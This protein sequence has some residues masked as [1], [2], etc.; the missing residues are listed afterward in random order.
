MEAHK[1]IFIKE[2]IGR[3]D[4]I[5][6]I[7]VYQRNYSWEAIHTMHLLND[8]ETI[9]ESGATKRHF[10]GSIVVLLEEAMAFSVQ[11]YTLIDGQQRITTFMLLL[12]AISEFYPELRDRI[13]GE[14]LHNKYGKNSEEQMKLHLLNEDAEQFNNLL[15]N[16]KDSVRKDC[17]MM[18]SYLTC[19][20]CVERWYRRF[21]SET[22]LK[23][24][25]MLEVVSI[26]LKMGEDDPQEIFESINSTG[27]PLS[28]ADL[29]RNFLLMGEREQKRLYDDYWI[30]LERL[31]KSIND[32]NSLDQFFFVFLQ[33]QSVEVI[34]KER[35]YQHFIAY[36]KRSNH[37]SKADFMCTLNHAAE[38]YASFFAA[39]PGYSP[40]IQ[41]L[42]RGLRELDQTTIYPF[43]YLIFNDY[44][45][46]IITEQVLE[47]TLQL[48]LT[49]LVRRIV[50]GVPSN[51]LKSLFCGLY[52][53]VFRVEANKKR[54]C[55]AI[56]KFLFTLSSRDKFPSEEDFLSQLEKV[57]LYS[58]LRLCRLILI[59]LENG[60]SKEHVRMDNMTIEH[61]MPQKLNAEWV[62][63]SPEEHNTYL[64]TLGNLTLTAMNAELSNNSF[65]K[66]KGIFRESKARLLNRDVI[67]KQTWNIID[68]QQRAQ[69]LARLVSKRFPAHAVNDPTIEFETAG[70]LT[71]ETPEL[72][73]GSKILSYIYRGEEHTC[74]NYYTL[75][76]ELILILDRERP[77]MLHEMVRRSRDKSSKGFKVN[78]EYGA[79]NMRRSIA[80][81][82]N[83]CVDIHGSSAT[84]LRKIR[85]LFA[86]YG[87]DTKLLTIRI[88]QT[89]QEKSDKGQTLTP[90]REFQ[91][92]FWRASY[93]SAQKDKDFTN[94][95]THELPAAHHWSV[96]KIGIPKCHL[97]FLIYPAKNCVGCEFYIIGKKDLFYALKNKC[98]QLE[99]EIG[100]KLHWYEGKRD[101]RIVAYLDGEVSN[102]SEWEKCF[103]WMR[104]T[105]IRFYEVFKS[106]I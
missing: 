73:T 105:A 64:H 65:E 4:A 94:R 37:P 87:I 104:L 10:L 12:L 103:T 95:F 55:D 60:N 89:N 5:F 47:E 1:N 81:R 25:H 72:A 86:Q 82:D 44:H 2:V 52:D 38:I 80:L 50:C 75:I 97:S 53:R 41:H 78:Y 17:S 91:I 39:E 59:E 9:L 96:V 42:L 56:N 36:Y 18:R 34:N 69:R 20:R 43:L 74:T 70:I 35:L 77:E 28:K 58:N 29:I 21:D 48:L 15:N 84:V 66:K 24:L 31:L 71:L 13:W 32:K 92:N 14:Y 30:P 51:S 19:R 76:R 106:H 68:I 61:I 26:T 79:E 23:A 57:D 8:I 63:I 22:I 45:N 33:A 98:D 99:R 102:P 6:T 40:R 16:K 27:L 3:T 62:H 67:D 49:Y 11:R 88:K 46:K 83:I 85:Y 54:Y 7:P 100:E 93:T 101:G 90:T